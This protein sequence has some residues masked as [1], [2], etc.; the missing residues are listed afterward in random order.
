MA[1]HDVEK[2]EKEYSLLQAN[3]AESIWNW[4]N[5]E[6]ALFSLYQCAI[7]FNAEGGRALHKAFFAIKGVEIRVSVTDAAMKYRWPTGSYIDE[8]VKIRT[9]LDK[10]RRS[11]G[12]LAHHAGIKIKFGEDGKSLSEVEPLVIL[13]EPY[14]HDEFPE[15]RQDA[16]N[17]GF[18][19]TQLG[20]LA[21]EFKAL[22][23][24]MWT[25]IM[26]IRREVPRV[27]RTQPDSK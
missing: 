15:S 19:A 1:G 26:R 21:E 6:A 23:A 12:R 14:V 11:R 9:R 20:E 27:P 25:L 24:D 10:S 17:R 16:I 22:D 2:V 8:W 18:S 13:V 5:I 4:A 7:G 3:F